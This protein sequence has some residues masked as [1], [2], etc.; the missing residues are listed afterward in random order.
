MT[1]YEAFEIQAEQIDA[2]DSADQE[3]YCTGA[4]DAAIFSPPATKNPAYL[5]GYFDTLRLLV[6]Q[7]NR[8]F[9]PRFEDATENANSNGGGDA[10]GRHDCDWLDDGG[11]PF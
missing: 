5:S 11:D 1:P 4:A 7:S 6:S 9:Q 8:T 2:Q 10:W 3:E